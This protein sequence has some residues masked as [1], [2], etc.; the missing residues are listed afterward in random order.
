MGYTECLTHTHMHH[1]P[2]LLKEQQKP[3]SPDSASSECVGL[4]DNRCCRNR[5]QKS[6]S[7]TSAG[8]S[9][10]RACLV[11]THSLSLAVA[12]C[13]GAPLACIHQL[14]TELTVHFC[15]A[16]KTVQ[17]DC[18]CLWHCACS[19]APAHKT[20]VLLCSLVP[21][22]HAEWMSCSA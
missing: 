19:A 15:S 13:L 7:L 3:M 22:E 11:R 2:T 17:R 10:S 8:L 14:L 21:V 1:F 12:F 18:T 20:N 5:W 16:S 9:F 4:T 6:T